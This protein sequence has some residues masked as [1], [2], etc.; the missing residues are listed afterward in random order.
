[1]DEWRA[2]LLAEVDE[3]QRQAREQSAAAELYVRRAMVLAC[4]GIPTA[5]ARQHLL[6]LVSVADYEQVAGVDHGDQFAMYDRV[7][8]TEACAA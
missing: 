6:P 3:A 4:A 2:R 8:Q 7:E 5:I 1:M